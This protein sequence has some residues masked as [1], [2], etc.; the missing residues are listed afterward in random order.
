M[1]NGLGN[2]IPA[3]RLHGHSRIGCI[4]PSANR[5]MGTHLQSRPPPPARLTPPKEWI[6]PDVI[7]QSTILGYIAFYFG[8]ETTCL[9]ALKDCFSSSKPHL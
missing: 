3:H 5:K 7:G 2:K 8:K 1:Q 4:T 9:S 6:T